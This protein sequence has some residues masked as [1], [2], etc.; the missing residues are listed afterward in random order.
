MIVGDGRWRWPL[1]ANA[2]PTAEYEDFVKS[3]GLVSLRTYHWGTIHFD[4][5]NFVEPTI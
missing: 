5:E 1:A 4:R 2:H 3:I